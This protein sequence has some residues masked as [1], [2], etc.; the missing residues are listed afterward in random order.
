[1]IRI[2][3]TLLF[4]GFS[5][6]IATDNCTVNE[7]EEGVKLKKIPTK[8]YCIISVFQKSANHIH[9]INSQRRFAK[10]NPSGCSVSFIP[11]PTV[12]GTTRLPKSIIEEVSVKTRGLSA[13]YNLA[14]STNNLCNKMESDC[15]K[16]FNTSN[17]IRQYCHNN[18]KTIC[19]EKVNSNTRYSNSNFLY[20]R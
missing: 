4:L 2:L 18:I 3:C 7:I 17:K 11:G 14:I 19:Y 9:L 16:F 8:S 12:I 6:V 15:S 1:M 5:Q 10:R 13:R 20:F